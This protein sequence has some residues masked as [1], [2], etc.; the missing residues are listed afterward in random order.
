[1]T[2]ERRS[3]RPS[4]GVMLAGRGFRR[5]DRLGDLEMSELVTDERV[6]AMETLCEAPAYVVDWNVSEAVCDLLHTRSALIEALEEM[7]GEF[8]DQRCPCIPR[9]RQLLFTI[10]AT[11]GEE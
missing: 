3:A 11:E 10:H 9:A 5:E 7:L 4:V 1:M 8:G 6:E 2:I